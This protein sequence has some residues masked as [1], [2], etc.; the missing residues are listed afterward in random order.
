MTV[1]DIGA[2][3]EENVCHEDVAEILLN[4]H[5]LTSLVTYSH[6]GKS[7]LFIREKKRPLFVCKLQYLHDTETKEK[8]LDAIV[9]SC[10][11]LKLIYLDSPQEGI[12]HK[13]SSL[14][15]LQRLKLYKFNT[16]EI[17]GVLNK[18]GRQI[19]HLTMIKGSRII[20]IGE[21]VQCCPNL[22]DLDFYMMD[23]LQYSLNYSFAFLQGLEILNSPMSATNL[24]YLICNTSRTLKRLA[25]DSVSFTD[26]DMSR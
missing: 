4:V 1:I 17:F 3:G 14:K 23:G 20:D 5:N 26:D 22:V 8:T 10:P 13:L 25:V 11:E 16:Q 24:K 12:L 21:I 7:L 6:V 18:I 19:Q 9:Q 2:L 15:N